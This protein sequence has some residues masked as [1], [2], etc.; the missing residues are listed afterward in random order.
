M[1]ISSELKLVQT[2]GRGFRRLVHLADDPDTVVEN[3]NKHMQVL[4][5]QD[6]M[7]EIKALEEMDAQDRSS[8][9]W[10]KLRVWRA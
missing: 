9:Q 6:R 1:H 10:E 7:A 5:D 2:M 4:D 3:A 8:D